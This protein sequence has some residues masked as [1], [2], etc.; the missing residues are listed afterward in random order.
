MI[1]KL[2]KYLNPFSLLQNWPASRPLCAVSCT[3]GRYFIIATKLREIAFADVKNLQLGVKHTQHLPFTTGFIGVCSY[4]HF[5]STIAAG[6]SQPSL[7]FRVDGALV[8]D[9]QEHT[10]WQTGAE[11]DLNFSAQAHTDGHLLTSER[12]AQ[13]AKITRL[14]LI[15][16]LSDADYL[17]HVD[18]IVND[19]R[20]GRYYLLNFLRFFTVRSVCHRELLIRLARSRVPY[21]AVIRKQR[22]SIY[23]FSPEQFVSLHLCQGKTKLTCSPI[24]GSAPRYQDVCKDRQA[25]EELILSAKDLAELHI[26]IDLARDDINKITV[27]GSTRVVN[28]A[29]LSS[30]PSVHHLTGTIQADLRAGLTLEEFFTAICPAASISGAPKIEVMRAIA[31]RESR[32]R[33]FCMGNI[34]CLDDGGQLDSSVLIRTL[35][36]DSSGFIYAAGGGI[37]L[38]SDA[39]K[40][41]QE[42]NIK[43][44][45]LREIKS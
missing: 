10:L 6:S 41:R 15:P 7:F 5:A 33:G 45:V 36:G 21:R 16:D 13:P 19:I 2:P 23:S 38:D 28:P 43:T 11:C 17:A 31:A 39:E 1:K 4:D 24:K 18:E 8:F 35:V 20:Q 42:I 9:Q 29:R 27:S 30:F 40:E 25:G 26:T 44:L 12:R 3:Q 34:F 22:C 32:P 14:E 37:V